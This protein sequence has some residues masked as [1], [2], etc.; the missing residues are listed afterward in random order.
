MSECISTFEAKDQGGRAQVLRVYAPAISA[1]TR[2]NPNATTQGLKEIRTADGRSVNRIA[3]GHYA[4]LFPPMD[5][6]SD[7]PDAP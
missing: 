7:D 1:G 5:L 2:G 3:K 4:I 6:F